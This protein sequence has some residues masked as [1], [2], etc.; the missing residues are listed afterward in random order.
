M[1]LLAAAAGAV[2]LG[3]ALWQRAVEEGEEAV[4]SPSSVSVD[5]LPPGSI[6]VEVLNGC[7]VP[8]VAAHL[9]RK[10]RQLGMDVI[11]EGNADSFA[12]LQSMVIDRGG[13][14]DKA[15]RVAKAL[16][17]PYY[18]QQ[19]RTDPGRLAEVTIVIGKDYRRLKLLE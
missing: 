2:L 14:L 7:G 6:R 10:V 12:Y 1:W 11:D 16:G 13:D 19:I 5:S 3:A 4:G 18:I 9:T 8:Q 17:I 15:R